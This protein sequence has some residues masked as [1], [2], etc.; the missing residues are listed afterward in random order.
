MDNE[1]ART[2]LSTVVI[3]MII[4]SNPSTGSQSE[5]VTPVMP[6]KI[7]SL[8]FDPDKL[9]PERTPP[10]PP[11]KKPFKES[12]VKAKP[13][14]ATFIVYLPEKS[15]LF[16]DGQLTTA[17]GAA[18]VFTTPTLKPN[19]LYAYDLK[20]VVPDSGGERVITTRVTFMV[21]GITKLNFK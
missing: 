18:R 5:G 14:K 3:V 17:T 13:D 11:T 19:S 15:K 2:V 6:E 10:Q 4:L 12:E 1:K 9:P 16:I 20:V 8:P 7:P 21:G